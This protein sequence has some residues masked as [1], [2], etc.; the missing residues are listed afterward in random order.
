MDRR[1]FLKAGSGLIAALSTAIVVPPMVVKNEILQPHLTHL[2]KVLTREK[3]LTLNPDPV[4]IL[5]P[6]GVEIVMR[7]D[8]GVK[9]QGRFITH[10][11]SF[12]TQQDYDPV[13]SLHAGK[14]YSIPFPVYGT[15]DLTMDTLPGTLPTWSTWEEN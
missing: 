9:F 1:Q 11:M 5:D 8:H 6:N 15:L 10:S 3:V 13:K 14:E 4:D 2:E 12:T 7:F